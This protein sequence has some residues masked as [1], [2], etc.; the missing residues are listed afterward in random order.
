MS[1]TKEAVR[2]RKPAKAKAAEPVKGAAVVAQSLLARTPDQ[3]LGPFY[4][5]S[6]KPAVT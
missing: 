5:L 6:L 2:T 3:I 4:P 1:D